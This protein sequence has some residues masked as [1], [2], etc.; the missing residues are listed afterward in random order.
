MSGIAEFIAAAFAVFCLTGSWWLSS[1]NLVA[2]LRAIPESNGTYADVAHVAE[3]YD[4]DGRSH[5]I[6]NWVQ[7]GNADIR[8]GNNATA[9][10]RFAKSYKG[11]L[12]EHCSAETNRNRELDHA[13]EILART[14]ACGNQK[15]PLEDGSRVE[16]C[17]ACQEL[18][19]TPR[20]G[21]R[22]T[23]KIPAS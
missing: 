7:A 20:R 10:A 22:R 2:V 19:A 17:R 21:R 23:A 14:C 6:A 16:R 1:Q 15:I 11:R 9:Y 18:D 13:L 8:N 3:D 12:A 4:G 5:N